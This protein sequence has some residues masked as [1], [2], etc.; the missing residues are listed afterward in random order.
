[1]T[2]EKLDKI[3]DVLEYGDIIVLNNT[4]YSLSKK[5]VERLVDAYIKVSQMQPQVSQENG[6]LKRTIEIVCDNYLLDVDKCLEINSLIFT[7]KLNF[8]SL[9]ILKIK[10]ELLSRFSG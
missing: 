2:K 4:I 3:K 8:A 5:G 9:I 10:N 6:G 1:M 7:D